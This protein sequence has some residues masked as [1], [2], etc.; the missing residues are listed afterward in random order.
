MCISHV[1]G[2]GSEPPLLALVANVSFT[3]RKHSPFKTGFCA[4]VTAH[5]PTPRTLPLGNKALKTT[6]V[7]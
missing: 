1:W 3:G 7:F 2:A 5:S 6:D 4:P